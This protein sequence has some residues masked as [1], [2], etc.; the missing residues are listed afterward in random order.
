LVPG[1]EYKVTGVLMDKATGA[2]FK[3]DDKEVT[4]EATFTANKKGTGTVEVEFIFDRKAIEDPKNLVVF[5]KLYNVEGKLVGLHE[6]LE[7]KAVSY[8][9]L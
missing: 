7:D 3:V 4:G 1:K 6:D 2:A 9:H 8:T 5:E